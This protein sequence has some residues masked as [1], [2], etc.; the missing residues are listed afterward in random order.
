[1]VIFASYFISAIKFFYSHRIN[2]D[3]FVYIL[4]AF[5]IISTTKLGFL[6]TLETTT[7]TYKQLGYSID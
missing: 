3:K 1:M 2:F 5:N 7:W 4:C 6:V